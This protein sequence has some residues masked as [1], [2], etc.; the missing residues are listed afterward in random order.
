MFLD[1]FQSVLQNIKSKYY[2]KHIR[3]NVNYIFRP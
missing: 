2:K 3:F 1:V